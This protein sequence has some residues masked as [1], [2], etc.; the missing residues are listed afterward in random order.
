[1]ENI[2]LDVAADEGFV[3]ELLRGIVDYVLATVG[4]LL[5]RY[6]FDAIAVSDDYGT[7]RALVI[8]P[9]VA[10][11]IGSALARLWRG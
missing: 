9:V 11:V 10:A 1:M 3:A 2:L 8:S 7:Q 4:I 5:D 6:E